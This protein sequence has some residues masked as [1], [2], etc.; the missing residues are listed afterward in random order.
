MNDFVPDPDG[1]DRASEQHSGCAAGEPTTV[2]VVDDSAFDRQLISQLL[3]PLAGLRVAF[4]ADG[5]EGLAAIAS[6]TP[7]VIL[8]DLVMPDIGSWSWSSGSGPSI[9][10]SR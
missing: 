9:R 8:T 2:L 4:A 10:R 1:G 5:R 6:A 7:S 3:T